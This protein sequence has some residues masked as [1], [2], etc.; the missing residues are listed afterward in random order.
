MKKL[1]PNNQKKISRRAFLKTGLLFSCISSPVQALTFFKRKKPVGPPLIG[2]PATMPKVVVVGAGAF[3]GWTALH[4]LRKGARVTLVDAWGPGNQ[5]AS[6]SGIT[7]VIRAIY[8]KDQIYVKMVARSQ[9]I[10]RQNEKRWKQKLFTR[11]GA[12]WMLQNDDEFVRASLPFLEKYGFKCDELSLT[13]AQRR[14]PQ[15]NFEGVKWI[16]YEEKAGYIEARRACKVVLDG[17]LAEGGKYLQ[18][19]VKPGTIKGNRLHDVILSDG[20]KLEAD[21]YVFACGSWLGKIFPDLLGPLIRPTRQTVIYFGIPP[22]DLRFVDKNLPVWIDFGER[23][24]Y[25]I[26]GDGR[27]GFKIADDTRGDPIDPTTDERKPSHEEFKLARKYLELRFPA[28]KGAPLLTA[29]ACVY[30]NSPD[31]HFIIDQHP[32]AENLWI[33]GGGSGHGF[34]H[35]PAVGELLASSILGE[36]SLPDFFKLSRF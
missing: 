31:H 13:R 20:S 32:Q 34:K 8:G 5:R 24:W 33:A 4:L 21:H 29:L 2:S 23:I 17:F 25:G 22:G 1:N 16:F 28:L 12:L 35:G 6:S 14:F 30:E 3:G 19:S 36:K 27:Y 26:P 18:L 7:R 15:I 9:Q 11:T 10:W